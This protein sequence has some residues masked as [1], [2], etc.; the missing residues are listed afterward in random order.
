MTTLHSLI[1]DVDVLLALA[2]ILLRFAKQAR[3][4][5]NNMFTTASHPIP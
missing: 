1:P 3:V 2:P 4:N 5:N